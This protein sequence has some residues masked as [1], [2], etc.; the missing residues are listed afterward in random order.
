MKIEW[1]IAESTSF[2]IENKLIIVKYTDYTIRVPFKV[3]KTWASQV[4]NMEEYVGTG[5]TEE[6]NDQ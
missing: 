1:K 5:K 4:I 3:V 2:D 6:T